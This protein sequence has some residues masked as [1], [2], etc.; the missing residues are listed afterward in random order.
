M[1]VYFWLAALLDT[2]SQLVILDG[3]Q[4]A[5]GFGERKGVFAESVAPKERGGGFVEF[6]VRP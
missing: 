4:L 3:D 1:R 2:G 5:I 6:K